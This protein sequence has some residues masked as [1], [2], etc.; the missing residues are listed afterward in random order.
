MCS[1]LPSG[2]GCDGSETSAAGGATR[3]TRPKRRG[4]AVTK[5]AATR[6]YEQAITKI[7]LRSM[8]TLLD[9]FGLLLTAATLQK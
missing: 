6:Q 8:L 7:K 5:S 2:N 9:V 3:Q 4:E 1:L